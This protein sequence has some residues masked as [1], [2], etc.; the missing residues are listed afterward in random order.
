MHLRHLQITQ[1]SGCVERGSISSNDA[2]R[3]SKDILAS[4]FLEFSIIQVEFV[5]DIATYLYYSINT[6]YEKR[7]RKETISKFYE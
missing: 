3:K 1:T 2:T 4:N 7:L 6:S 5:F